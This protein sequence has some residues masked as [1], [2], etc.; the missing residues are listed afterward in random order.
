[1]SYAEKP[2]DWGDN[3]WFAAAAMLVAPFVTGI[4]NHW[5]HQLVMIGSAVY[6][7]LANLQPCAYAEL[8]RWG[9][10]GYDSLL[11]H[12]TGPPPIRHDEC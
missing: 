9:G 1:M 6:S 3:I 10:C 11:F 8:K 7:S 4:C 12:Q 5:F 2:D